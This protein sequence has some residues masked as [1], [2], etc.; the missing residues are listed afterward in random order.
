M[1]FYKKSS[2]PEGISDF[3]FRIE[4]RAISFQRS[5]YPPSN[6]HYKKYKLTNICYRPSLLVSARE[7]FQSASHARRFEIVHPPPLSEKPAT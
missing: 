3:D 5:N 6:V 4:N 2:I 7:E 1:P